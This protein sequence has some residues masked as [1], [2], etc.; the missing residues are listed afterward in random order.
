MVTFAIAVFLLIIT[1]GPGVLSLAGVGTAYGWKMGLRYLGGLCLG[2]NLVCFAVISGLAAVILADPVIRA[3]LFFAS[4]GYLTYLAVKIGFA[5]TRIA[6][7]HM[8]APGFMSGLTLQFINPK[9][10][11]VNATLFSGFAFYPS[12]FLI[13]TTVKLAITNAIW[14]PLHLLWLFAGVK[15]NNLDLSHKA[16][17]GIN[18]LM[19][20][21]LIAVV[22]ISIWSVNKMT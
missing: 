2:T 9:A 17:R 12:S 6:F 1:P 16:Q 10:Y 22:A 15:L 8:A 3:V 5:G 4:A 18:L 14:L 19:A 13:E 21:C 7:I 20:G 11:A